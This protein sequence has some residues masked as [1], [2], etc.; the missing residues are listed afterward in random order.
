MDRIK[1]G[2][3]TEVTLLRRTYK[4]MTKNNFRGINKISVGYLLNIQK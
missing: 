2:G 1:S 4:N 3:G